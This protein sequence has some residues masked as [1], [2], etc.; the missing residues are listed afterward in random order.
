MKITKPVLLAFILLIIVGSLCRVAGFA[1]QIAMAV[2][3]AAV[4]RDKKLAL[5][6][7]LVSMLLSDLLYEVLFRYG[8]A[9]YGGFYE[10]QIT[11]YVLIL[12]TAVFGFWAA[13]LRPARIV[14][15][16]LAA[17]TFYFFLSNLMVWMGGGGFNRPKTFDGLLMCFND[18]VPFFR[19]GLVTTIVTSAFL[20]GG[21][22]LVR[23]L[24][25]RKQTA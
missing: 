24:S 23:Q 13:N 14:A 16:T 3:G 20:F 2:F 12:T 6:L 11:N 9:P 25:L 21:Y 8:Y 17:P 7:P 10:G 1:P 22:F 18:A 5:L 19:N 4:I 15:A